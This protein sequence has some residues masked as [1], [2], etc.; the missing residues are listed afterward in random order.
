MGKKKCIGLA[1]I[2][3]STML[4]SSFFAE[5][6]YAA[7][8]KKTKKDS[9]SVSSAPVSSEETSL[10]DKESNLIKVIKDIEAVIISVRGAKKSYL[11]EIRNLAAKKSQLE[12]EL[13]LVQ[14]MDRNRAEILKSEIQNTVSKINAFHSHSQQKDR[15]ISRLNDKMFA[16]QRS[17]SDIR[18]ARDLYAVLRGA[19]NTTYKDVSE[20]EIESVI[21]AA[22]TAL[23]NAGPTASMNPSIPVQTAKTTYE[24]PAPAT[25]MPVQTPQ[26]AKAEPAAKPTMKFEFK[27]DEPSPIATPKNE[28]ARITAPHEEKALDSARLL[29]LVEKNGERG[30]SKEFGAFVIAKDTNGD[31]IIGI[32]PE[33]RKAFEKK[34]RSKISKEFADDK[35]TYYVGK[36]YSE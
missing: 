34:Y 1:A 25:P 24:V 19:S 23:A 35:F 29:K 27:P 7:S 12:S 28:P 33:H 22:D 6:T 36:F 18:A 26:I 10:A 30:T 2:L 20:A 14:M 9:A 11:L 16:L 15:D 31:L 8:P 21:R 13:S 17:L 5:E 4:F 3:I 32:K